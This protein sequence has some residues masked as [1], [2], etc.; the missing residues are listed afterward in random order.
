MNAEY[1]NNNAAR[2]QRLSEIRSRGQELKVEYAELKR[3]FQRIAMQCAA[4]SLEECRQDADCGFNAMGDQ[5]T[6]SA[7]HASALY[8]ATHRY[9]LAAPANYRNRNHNY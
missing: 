8:E 5:C 2:R 4:H 9:R 1:K 6:P 7:A 3:E